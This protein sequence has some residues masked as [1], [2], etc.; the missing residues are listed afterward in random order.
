MKI[1]FKTF[2][3]FLCAAA[4]I[5]QGRVQF[6][7]PGGM[8]NVEGNNSASAP[9]N[10]TSFRFQQ[11]FDASQFAIPPGSSGRIN[12]ISFR[13]DGAATSNM[14]LYFGG[15][16]WTLST[17]PRSPDSLSPVFADNRGPNAVTA[18][19][20]AFSFGGHPPSPGMPGVFQD[21]TV[22]MEN[23]FYYIPSQG[24]LLLEV[25]AGSGRAFFPGALD[26]HAE[27]GDSISWVFANASGPTMGTADT[28]GL[29]TRFD[30]T[31]IPEPAAWF[32]G[33]TGLMLLAVF[34]RR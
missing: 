34:R 31:I 25:I 4:A 14:T 12:S 8:A 21:P 9:F 20:G 13:I 18:S 23:P 3:F 11:V 33:M 7:V 24:N 19:T 10:S 26:G 17:T 28:F 1:L 27:L 6:V 30:I 2:L 15:S 22:E 29:V 16:S 32:L 5:G